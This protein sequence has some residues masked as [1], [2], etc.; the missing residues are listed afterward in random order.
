M[1]NH[2]ISIRTITEQNL[3]DFILC[4]YKFYYEYIEKKKSPLD[5][6]KV[7]QQVV[8]RI[9]YAYYQLPIEHRHATKV[10][11]LIEQ[12]WLKISP[13]FFES[14]IQYYQVVAKVTDYLLQDLTEVSNLDPPLLLFEKYKT[15][16]QELDV[17]LALTFDVV[18]F[19]NSSFVVKKYVVQAD[20]EMLKLY[21]F[22][23]QVFSEKVFQIRPTR[24]EVITLIDQKKHIFRPTQETL[25]E[26]TSYLLLMKHFLEDSAIYSEIYNENECPTCPF[27][28]VCNREA[29]KLNQ[30]KYLS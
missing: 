26:G 1:K 16:I 15:H 4:P 27:Q 2:M 9:V 8:H 29:P 17:D 28:N 20:Q 12:H 23:I 5:W 11:E 19:S 6:R 18:N 10:L 21:Y 3:K 25:D 22:L 24:V 13:Q 7:V 14:N 30:A